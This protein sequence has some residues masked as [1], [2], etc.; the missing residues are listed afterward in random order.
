MFIS[1]CRPASF[2]V[3][4]ALTIAQKFS[5]LCISFLDHFSIQA[6]RDAVRTA[7]NTGVLV[8]GERAV[9][10]GGDASDVLTLPGMKLWA[11]PDANAS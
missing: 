2:L 6:E 10:I 7:L 5:F 4:C 3:G 1:Q 8:T 11:N 9:A